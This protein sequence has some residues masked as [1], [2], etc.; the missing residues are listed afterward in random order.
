VAGKRFALPNARVLI[1]QPYGGIEGLTSKVLRASAATNALL[2]A[3]I[4]FAGKLLRHS[5]ESMTLRHYIEMTEQMEEDS[6][7]ALRSAYGY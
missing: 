3:N 1:H 5:N 2:L 7:A 6:W 4:K